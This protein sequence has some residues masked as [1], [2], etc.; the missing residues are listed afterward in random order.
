MIPNTCA[1][2]AL[3]CNFCK[4]SQCTV[5][6]KDDFRRCKYFDDVTYDREAEEKDKEKAKEER[7]IRSLFQKQ[8]AK[9]R[10]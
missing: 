8:G 5:R 2:R 7:R 9:T 4:K 3:C 6:C 1:D 10:L